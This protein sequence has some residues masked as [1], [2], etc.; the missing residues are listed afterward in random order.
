MKFCDLVTRAF[1][2]FFFSSCLT[3]LKM[4]QPGNF[5]KDL[6]SSWIELDLIDGNYVSLIYC[7][8]FYDP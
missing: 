5:I 7:E 6:P 4:I 1:A 2:V 3:G 8:K